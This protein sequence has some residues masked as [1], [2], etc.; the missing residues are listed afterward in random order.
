MVCM[1]SLHFESHV[2][3]TNHHNLYVPGNP[4]SRSELSAMCFHGVLR[5]QFGPYYVDA[6]LPDTASQ[7]AKSVRMAAEQL[8]EGSWTATLLT[9]TWIHLGG[10]AP[11]MLEAATAMAHRGAARHRVVSTAL[12]H[13]DYLHRADVRDEDLQVI[14]GV[15]VTSPALT[16]EELL[17]IGGTSRHRNKA[18]QLCELV[19]VDTLQQRFD[20]DEADM[21]AVRAL[22]QDLQDAEL[23]A[24]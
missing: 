12:R 5:P 3:P 14:G 19:N 13:A 22:F 20:A 7:R 6:T 24:T 8:I 10:I 15:V 9:A 4:Y 11:E 23:S 16:I 17:K 2:S 18:R 1:A 21:D